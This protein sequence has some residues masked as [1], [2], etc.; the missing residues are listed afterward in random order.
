MKIIIIY[1]LAVICWQVVKSAMK[2]ILSFAGE[3]PKTQINISLV[4][5]V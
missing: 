5:R 4:Y 1:W 2:E 3:M